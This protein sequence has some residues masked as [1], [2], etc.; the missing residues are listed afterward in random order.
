[1][2]S[3]IA[4]TLP[5]GVSARSEPAALVRISASAPSSFSARIGVEIA[6]PSA[7]S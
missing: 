4:T 3:E 2:W 7:P 6:A 1:M 5:G